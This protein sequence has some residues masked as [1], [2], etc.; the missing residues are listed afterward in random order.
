MCDRPCKTANDET[1]A[2]DEGGGRIPPLREAT[3]KTVQGCLLR[4]TPAT[5]TIIFRE[6]S[7][8]DQDRRLR[9]PKGVWGCAIQVQVTTMK[10]PYRAASSAPK[11]DRPILEY[12]TKW[13]SPD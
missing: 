9:H 2:R 7:P 8:A 1:L 10:I 4:T 13:S 12:T 11:G 6:L 3:Y 5:P